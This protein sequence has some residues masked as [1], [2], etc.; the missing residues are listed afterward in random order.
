MRSGG[1]RSQLYSAESWA[2]AHW[3]IH[4]KGPKS[5]VKKLC[6]ELEDGGSIFDAYRKTLNRMNRDSKL[7]KAF[8][9]YVEK[10]AD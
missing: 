3:V 7:D 6:K 5:A 4:G 8:D 10:L 2:F 1:N 9:N